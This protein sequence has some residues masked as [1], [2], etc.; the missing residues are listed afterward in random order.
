MR[1]RSSGKSNMR[2]IAIILTVV[3]VLLAGLSVYF[4]TQ[5]RHLRN[6]PN[7]VAE[8][9]TKRIIAKVGKLYALPSGETPTIAQVQEKEK[10]KDQAFFKDAHDGDYILIYTKAKVALIYREADNKIINVGPIALSEG[11]DGTQSVANKV[12]VKVINGTNKDGRA[13]AV[14]DELSSKLADK[15]TVSGEYGNAKARTVIKTTVVAINPD[16]TAQAQE[17]ADALGGQVGQLPAGETK[18]DADIL[19]IAGQ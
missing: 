7:A 5:Y 3:I 10:L 6:N 4:F 11:N 17:I 14:A 9:N 15:V 19:V 12:S 2:F 1:Y 13:Q 18:P 16:K 8:D